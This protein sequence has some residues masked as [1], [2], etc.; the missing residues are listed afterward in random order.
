MKEE[1]EEVSLSLG[2]GASH[3]RRRFKSAI[4]FVRFES[5]RVSIYGVLGDGESPRGVSREQR[6]AKREEESCQLAE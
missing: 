6:R 5:R 2:L 1:G 4:K 3:S